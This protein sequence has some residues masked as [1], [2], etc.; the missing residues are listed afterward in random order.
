EHPL[1]GAF[2]AAHNAVTGAPLPLGNKPFVDDGSSY[3]GVGGIAAIS[4]G[5][6]ATGAHTLNEKAPVAEL[7][8]VAQVYALTAVAFCHPDHPM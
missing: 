4:H 6:A 7:V 2:Q 3:A 1:I 8:R 5:P